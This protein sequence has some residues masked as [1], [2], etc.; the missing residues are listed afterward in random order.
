MSLYKKEEI[1]PGSILK[2][3]IENKFDGVFRLI[4]PA[5]EEMSEMEH[6]RSPVIVKRRWLVEFVGEEGLSGGERFTQANQKGKRTHRTIRFVAGK[7]RNLHK[8]YQY[9]HPTEGNRDWDIDSFV[10]DCF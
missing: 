4:E 7:F 2:N 9:L 5:G 10:F 1:F 3:F 6:D 8:K